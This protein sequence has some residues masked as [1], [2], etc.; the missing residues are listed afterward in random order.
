[1]VLVDDQA[2]LVQGRDHYSEPLAAFTCAGTPVHDPV[3]GKVVGALSLTTWSRRRPDLLMALAAQTAMNVEAQM[4][5]QAGASSVRQLD[6][7][8]RAI[9]VRRDGRASS[10]GPRLTALEQLEREA[11]VDALM[12]C[13]GRVAEA[14]RELGLSRATT[15]RRIRHYRIDLGAL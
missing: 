9:A 13:G 4:A 1:M 12:R 15:Y 8:L 2:S 3:S 11:M 10:T 5:A 7:Y 14:S 6:G